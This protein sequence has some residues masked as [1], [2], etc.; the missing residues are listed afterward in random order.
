LSYNETLIHRIDPRAKLIVT[1]AFIVV[2]VSFHKYALMSL[3]PFLFFPILMVY[4][5]N[6]PVG[7]LL[8]KLLIV[9]PFALMICIFNPFIDREVIAYLG[10]FAITGGWVSFG[11]VIL[12]FILTVGAALI[13]IATT[14]FP[15]ICH[16]LD[17]VLEL[18]E[19]TVIRGD[20]RVAADGKTKELFLDEKLLEEN[21]LERPLSMQY[22]RLR[23]AGQDS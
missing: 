18:C 17:M 14:S 22:P 19:R 16:A 3:T 4:L 20:G 10:P 9:S 8:K 6:L 2:V 1:A 13:L 12:R 11:S 23:L 7:Y 21:G 5:G 15:G